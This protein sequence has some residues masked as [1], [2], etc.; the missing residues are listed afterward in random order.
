[1]GEKI[2]TLDIGGY[3]T[4]QP[5]GQLRWVRKYKCVPWER[6]LQQEFQVVSRKADGEYGSM[7]LEWRDVPTEIDPV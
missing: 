1:M 2:S 7:R 3:E 6:T 4:C 5:T